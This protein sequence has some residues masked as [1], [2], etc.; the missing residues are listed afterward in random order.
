MGHLTASLLSNKPL[1]VLRQT[2]EEIKPSASKQANLVRGYSV[3]FT[4]ITM[5]LSLAHSGRGKT[6]TLTR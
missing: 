6:E 5:K 2:E 1:T 3:S 4:R